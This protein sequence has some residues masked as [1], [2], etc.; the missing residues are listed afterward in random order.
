MIDSERDSANRAPGTDRATGP[1]VEPSVRIV[2]VARRP[3]SRSASEAPRSLCWHCVPFSSV[4]RDEELV[5]ETSE[6]A[7]S[8]DNADS[9]DRL[10][11]GRRTG[12]GS[13]ATPVIS[14][15]QYPGLQ[16]SFRVSIRHMM[17]A[18]RRINAT[19]AI[20][21][22]RR[23]LIPWNH[24]R[25]LRSLS[26]QPGQSR[27]QS[28]CRRELLRRHLLGQPVRSR[29]DWTPFFAGRECE[30]GEA[31]HRSCSAASCPPKPRSYLCRAHA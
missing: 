15:L 31:P 20:P 29:A 10:V 9:T 6:L 2:A 19:R 26:S 30:I 13:S 24:A 25:A 14:K 12:R 4:D 11:H 3:A 8:A 28:N 18:S 5:L 17:V 27:L 16:G 1:H 7:S 23:R 21:E 22:P